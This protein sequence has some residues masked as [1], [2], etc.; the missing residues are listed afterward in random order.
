MAIKSERVEARL[1]SDERKLIDQAAALAGQSLSAFMVGAAGEKAELVIAAQATTVVPAEYFD[2]L[3][4]AIDRADRA[5]AL[6][7][8]AKRARRWQRIE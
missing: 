4:S 7:R 6:A 2:R 8:A 5:P 1:S 3:L